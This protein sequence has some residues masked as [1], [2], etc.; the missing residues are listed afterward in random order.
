RGDSRLLVLPVLRPRIA[1]AKECRQ[2]GGSDGESDGWALPWQRHGFQV[3]LGVDR[4]RRT[5]ARS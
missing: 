5:F 1:S 2:R 3:L 4:A